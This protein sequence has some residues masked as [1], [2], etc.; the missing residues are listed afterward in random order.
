MQV[1][2]LA[3]G[4]GNRLGRLGARYSKP[5]IPILGEPMISVVLRT[6]APLA[7]NEIIVVGNPND[8]ALGE[9][10]SAWNGKYGRVRLVYQE[11]PLGTAHAL[12]AAADHLDEI[13]LLT[14]SD[15]LV[16]ADEIVEFAAAVRE[17][18]S[19]EALL[20]V[21]RMDRARIQE[22]AAVTLD[23]QG[24]VRR[25]VEKP[26]PDEATSRL[27][28]LPLYAF[29]RS[30]LDHM[31][32]LRPSS[33]GEYEIPSGIQRLIDHGGRVRAFMWGK[34]MTVNTAADY[35]DVHLRLLRQRGSRIA[36]GAVLGRELNLRDPVVVE[37]G[38]SLG[39][40]SQIG[41]LVYVGEQARV[42]AGARIERAVVMPGAEVPPGARVSDQVL[43]G[44]A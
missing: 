21:M 37:A 7:P 30:V 19:C 34:R 36:E 31:F 13:F 3:A 28:A 33:R 29:R 42:G 10:V 14:A 11:E 26:R 16:E 12:Q 6:F 27:A 41:P 35:L 9:H 17:M 8:T 38:A 23:G 40:E 22:S 32:A 24:E 4:R 43:L 44:S 20:S 39:D 1:V 18:G 2:I 25:V 5:M 15:H